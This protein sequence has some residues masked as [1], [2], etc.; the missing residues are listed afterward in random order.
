MRERSEKGE[1]ERRRG[2]KEESFI[3]EK[4]W[5]YGRG[6]RDKYGRG[7]KREIWRKGL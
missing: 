3:W 6:E 1:R 7:V 2:M 4:G 5:R